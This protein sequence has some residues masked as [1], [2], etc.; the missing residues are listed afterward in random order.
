MSGV[1]R[2]GVPGFSHHVTQRGNRRANGFLEAIP[3]RRAWRHQPAESEDGYDAAIRR[4]TPTGRPC[5][6]PGS[7]NNAKRHR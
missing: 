3:D 7:S 1:A 2:I 5:G 6:A 4:Q